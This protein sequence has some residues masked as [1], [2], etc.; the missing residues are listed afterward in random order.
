MPSLKNSIKQNKIPLLCRL[1]SLSAG[2]KLVFFL[3]FQFY[4]GVILSSCSPTFP[5]KTLASQLTKLAKNE[6]KIFVVCHITGKTLWIY[7]P[8]ED[9]VNEKDMSWNE[10]GLEKLNKIISIAHRGALSTDAQLDFIAV[11]ATDIKY[12]GVQ[13]IN[14]E[15]VPDLKEAMFEKFSRGEYF[16][17][18]VKDISVNP[19]AVN[20][21]TGESTNFQDVTFDHFI[22]MQLEHRTK[23]LFAKDKTL[24]KLFELKSTSLSEKFGTIKLEFEFLKKTYILTPE[25][26]KIKPLDYVKMVAA[27]I[28]QN[29]NYK[30]MQAFELKDTFSGETVTMDVAALKKIEIRLP[31]LDN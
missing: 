19:A 14:Y 15:Y 5:A 4:L 1:H 13:L 24:N 27:K 12:F 3:A 7:L 25:E 6:E 17:R 18:S 8:L 2:P 23:M 30:G 16:L 21:T 26:E 10:K 29:Y 11:A 20:D 22:G 9:L 28:A 31:E